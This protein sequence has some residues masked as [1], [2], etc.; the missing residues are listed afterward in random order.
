MHWKLM[1]TKT[2]CLELQLVAPVLYNSKAA[3]RD[4]HKNMEQPA[5]GDR[6]H[7]PPE[8]NLAVKFKFWFPLHILMH[9]SI[10][11]TALN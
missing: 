6:G 4:F 11:Y 7:A 9:F 2:Y 1:G 3:G 5:W 8:N 10:M